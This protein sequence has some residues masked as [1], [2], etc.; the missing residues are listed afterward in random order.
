MSLRSRRTAA[1]HHLLNVRFVLH[2]FDRQGITFTEVVALALPF[3]ETPFFIYHDHVVHR[4][5][6]T[7]TTMTL[8]HPTYRSIHPLP[9]ALSR[10]K[11]LEESRRRKHLQVLEVVVEGLLR[12]A[13]LPCS[14]PLGCPVIEWH[15][16]KG[17]FA[18]GKVDAFSTLVPTTSVAQIDVHNT[19]CFVLREAFPHSPGLFAGA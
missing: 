5:E 7:S 2:F 13:Q 19:V 12:D 4:V 18:F 8:S 9:L 3:D 14:S 10:D 16:S 6:F 1:K 11:R 15:L 17:L